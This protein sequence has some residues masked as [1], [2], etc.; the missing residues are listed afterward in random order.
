MK[1][2][3]SFQTRDLRQSVAFYETLLNTRAAKNRP[4]YVLFLT[5]CPALALALNPSSS[6]E[7]SHDTH[8]GIS[9]D[10]ADDVSE[11]HDRLLKAGI[12]VGMASTQVCCYANQRKIWTSDPDGRAWEVYA[13]LGETS[14]RDDGDCCGAG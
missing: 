8:F 3:L 13:V 7:A 2:H 11:A 12:R 6:S 14:E 9:V 10:S 1:T 4:D 5:D